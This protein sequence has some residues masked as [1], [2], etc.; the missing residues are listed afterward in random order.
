MPKPDIFSFEA[1]GT[2]WWIE[3][4]DDRPLDDSVRSELRAYAGRFDQ[5]Y[6]RFLEGS[7]ITRLNTTGELA[8]PPGELVDMLRFCEDMYRASDG[9][10]NISVGGRLHELGYGSRAQAGKIYDDPWQEIHY[11]NALVTIPRD[12]TLD[13]GG[14]GKGWLI[15]AFADLLRGH[16]YRHFIINGGGDMYIDSDESVEIALEHPHDETLGVGSTRI[17]RGALAASGTNKRAWTHAGKRYHHIIDPHAN[18]SLKTDVAGVYVRADS[19][20]IADTMATILMIRPDLKDVLSQ[21]YNFKAIII[22]E[23][24]LAKN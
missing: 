19:A 3:S 16:G 23:S 21:K 24:Q 10:F 8:D 13:T 5:A 11:D 9:A 14:Y 4:L 6:S 1:I 20:L 12:M 7:L 15:D 17:T 18:A 22:R 2:H